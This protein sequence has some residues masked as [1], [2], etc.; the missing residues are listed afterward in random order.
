MK[1]LTPFRHPRKPRPICWRFRGSLGLRWHQLRFLL[2]RSRRWHRIG[3]NAYIDNIP[4]QM[5]AEGLWGTFKHCGFRRTGSMP[6][7]TEYLPGAVRRPVLSAHR[8]GRWI[9]NHLPPRNSQASFRAK[10]SAFRWVYRFSIWRVLW[11]L[12]LR[13][14]QFP[15][16]IRGARV[17]VPLQ[18][19]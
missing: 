1:V 15:R 14:T 6:T 5:V 8:E 13:L 12:M 4:R 10:S 7:Q 17:V 2:V 16:Q 11:P 18:H 19:G 9:Q 3:V